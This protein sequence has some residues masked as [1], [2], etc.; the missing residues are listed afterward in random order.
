MLQDVTLLKDIG[1]DRVESHRFQQIAGIPEEKFEEHIISVSVK[2]GNILKDTVISRGEA[3]LG[4]QGKT[5]TLPPNIDKKQSHKVQT[6][7]K[8]LEVIEEIKKE[9]QVELGQI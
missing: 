3:S 4:Y 9:R 1:I 8:N 7:A 6:I 2:L 5:K